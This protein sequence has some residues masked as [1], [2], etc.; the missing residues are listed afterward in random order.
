MAEI[1]FDMDTT[2]FLNGI[3]GEEGLSA[4]DFGN[5]LVE[6]FNEKKEEIA[7]AQEERSKLKKAERDKLPAIA[8]RPEITIVINSVGGEY[9][10]LIQMYDLLQLLDA[11]I[12]TVVN[13][14]AFSAAAILAITGT[15]GK[16]YATPKSRLMF[17]SVS[18]GMEGKTADIKIDFTESERLNHQLRTIIVE[19]SQGKLTQGKA[20]RFIGRDCY[21]LPEEAIKLGLIDEIITKIG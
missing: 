17:H 6:T 20:K 14:A 9:D 19:H 15:C 13:G 12:R 11:D 1:V 21:V 18:S 3:I 7:A 8:T 10:H 2:F 16:R 4:G 5:W